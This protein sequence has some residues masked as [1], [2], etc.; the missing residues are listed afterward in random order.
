[1]ATSGTATFNPTLL[2]M[3]E[4]AYERAGLEYRVGYDDVTARRSFNLLVVELSNRQL[5]MWEFEQMSIVLSQ[6]VTS[7]SLPADS[8]D[9]LEG[10]IRI[11]PGNAFTQSDIVISRQSFPDYV[12]VPNKLSQGRPTQYSILRGTSGMTCYFYPTP[13]GAAQYTFYYLRLRRTQDAG[14]SINNADVPFRFYD[15]VIAGLAYRIASKR[16][17]AMALVPQLK[18]VYEEALALAES[19]DRDRSSIRLVPWVNPIQ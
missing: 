16:R 18:A 5:N 3:F 17:E 1:M 11:N 15:A 2:E 12:A 7:Y 6:G 8:I 4:E 9:V 10:T 14:R 19:E 13:D